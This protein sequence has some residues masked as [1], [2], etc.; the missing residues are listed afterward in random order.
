MTAKR[1]KPR[2]LEPE[3]LIKDDPL[4]GQVFTHSAYG[5]LAVSRTSGSKHLY[6]SEFSHQHYVS[7]ELHES[8]RHRSLSRDWHHQNKMLAR[9]CLSE[10]QWATFV[11]AVGQ[12]AGVPCTIEYAEGKRRGEVPPPQTRE[13]Y[14]GEAKQAVEESVIELDRLIARIDDQKSKMSAKL[15]A[16]LIGH[17]RNAKARLT[18]TL[19]FIVDSFA[20]HMETT[21]EQAK[22]EVEA[23]VS[24]TVQRAGLEA[25]GLKA[26]P[27]SLAYDPE[28]GETPDA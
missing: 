3:V 5:Q 10:A 11:A 9:I 27:L 14:H 24:Q 25:I 18:S 19:P 16:D 8:E 15:A 1:H 21:V 2:E 17:V 26:A 4:H 12:G 28:P 6:G 7:I 20:E 13:L 22:I 23:I